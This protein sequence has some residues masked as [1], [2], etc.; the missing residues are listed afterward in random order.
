MGTLPHLA[1]LVPP[2]HCYTQSVSEELRRHEP[3]LRLIFAALNQAD[4]GSSA[5][6]ISMFEWMT[7]LRCLGL[8]AADLTERDVR[9]PP[10]P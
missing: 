1:S 4:M 10:N 2:G 8:I 7:Y 3:T 6:L 9:S 5:V